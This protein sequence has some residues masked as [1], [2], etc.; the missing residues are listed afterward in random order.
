[1]AK[2]SKTS[3]T[4]V[5]LSQAVM[6]AN[7]RAYEVAMIRE[8]ALIT[9]DFNPK[10]R[11]EYKNIK[12]LIESIDKYGQMNTCLVV[13]VK[14][15]NDAEFIVAE[16]NRRRSSLQ[17][18]NIK[19]VFCHIRRD[20]TLEE[21]YIE[22]NGN[23]KQHTGNESAE[24]Y[25]MNHDCVKPNTKAKLDIMFKYL[26]SDNFDW[27]LD[28]AGSQRTFQ[29]IRKAC[30]FAGWD[31]TQDN[32]GMVMRWLVLGDN[33]ISVRDNDIT[34][35]GKDMFRQVILTNKKFADFY[36]FYKMT[37]LK[38][39]VEN[40][41]NGTVECNVECTVDYSVKQVKKLA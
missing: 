21:I 24:A 16:G 10:S 6:N 2:T 26:G 39:V 1:M 27:L 30:S 41:V 15:S 19:Y 7:G 20:V 37:H 5:I 38:Q 13:P 3:K 31:D 11:T 9:P 34:L 25:R 18:L 22:T 29:T 28:H 12:K 14:G 35:I 17:V 23:I 4:P 33:I 40:S 32:I 36:E 8:D